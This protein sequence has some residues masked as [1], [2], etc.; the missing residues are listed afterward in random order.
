MVAYQK[1]PGS[2]SI[3]DEDGNVLEEFRLK[4]TALYALSRLRK[5]HGNNL[6]VVTNI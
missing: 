5:I 2:Y 3:V 4:G 1:E 6:K